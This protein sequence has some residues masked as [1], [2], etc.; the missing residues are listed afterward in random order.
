MTP[1]VDNADEPDL[2]Q[3]SR[4]ETRVRQYDEHDQLVSETI[5][6]ITQHRRPDN[7]FPIGMYL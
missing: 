3:T 6:V 1:T 7:D 4:T 5:T 2:E